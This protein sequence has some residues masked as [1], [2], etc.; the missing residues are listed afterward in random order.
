MKRKLAE[1]LDQQQDEKLDPEM[2]ATGWPA[3][4]FIRQPIY[5]RIGMA[6][7]VRINDKGITL[8]EMRAG[9]YKFVDLSWEQLFRKRGKQ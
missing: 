1:R 2:S 8:R 3:H 9:K 6:K 4:S 7:D 5:R